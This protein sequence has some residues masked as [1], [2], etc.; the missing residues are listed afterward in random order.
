MLLLE[1]RAYASARHGGQLYGDLPYVAHLDDVFEIADRHGLE[2]AVKRAAYGH[3]LLDDTD[4]TIDDLRREFGHVEADIIYSVSG[5]GKNRAARR[6][7]TIRRLGAY[8]RGIELKACDRIANIRSCIKQKNLRLLKMYLA[9]KGDY[10]AVFA[11]AKD[12][13]Q[14]ELAAAYAEAQALIDN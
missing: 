8:Q 2:P 5:V 13:L 6:A 3:D 14:Q 11:R 7:E 12:S 4:A 10:A 1:L 9:E